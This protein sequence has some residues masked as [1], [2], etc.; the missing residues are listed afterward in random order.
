MSSLLPLTCVLAALSVVQA[1][2]ATQQQVTFD[3]SNSANIVNLFNPLHHLS[4]IAPYWQAVH[5]PTP[6]P[7]TCTVKSAAL[8]IRHS[9][10]LANDD[11]WYQTMKPFED[12]LKNLSK[13]AFPT[14]G[15]WAFLKDWESPITEKK[16]E[17]LSARGKR[18]AKQYGKTVRKQY[19]NL[20]PNNHPSDSDLKKKKHKKDK[21]KGDGKKPKN[22]YKVWTASSSRDI[23]SSKSFILGAFPRHQSGPDGKGDGDEVELVE[24]PNKAKDW[25]R[26]LTPHKA[27]AA[28]EKES[29]LEPAGVWLATYAPRVRER[30]STLIPNVPL[31]DEDILGMQMLCGY[32]SIGRGSSPFCEVFTDQEWLD[33]EYY[34]D[35]R[36]HYMMGYGNKISPYLGIPWVTTAAHLLA[37]E[38]AHDPLPEDQLTKGKS[39]LPGPEMPPNG[40]HSQFLFPFFTHRESP[41][42]VAT[43]L[44]LFTPPFGD[45]SSPLAD[46]PLTHRDD[47]RAWRTSRLVPFLGNIALERLTCA[48]GD[49]VRAVVNGR[50]E[51]MA[52]CDAWIGG[53]CG[54]TEW[55]DWVEKRTDQWKGWEEVCEKKKDL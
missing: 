36:F 39:K 23:E 51:K 14:T 30:L 24:I 31:V 12:K 19:D 8:L 35:V 4:A 45:V 11:E 29:S 26:S 52:G 41:A 40:T 3:S 10:I 46:P 53:T 5:E 43:A 7:P 22:S 48:D 42:F 25:D 50:M 34:F 47:N 1:A 27:C 38:E 6:L 55:Q 37:G 32:E 44:S 2:P 15:P 33:V 16:L 9:A 20:F 28:F 17:V 13:S 49:V 21:K 18:D 54:W